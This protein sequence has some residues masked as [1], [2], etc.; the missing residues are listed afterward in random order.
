MKYMYE[1]YWGIFHDNSSTIVGCGYSGAASALNDIHKQNLAKVGPLPAG[2]YTIAEVYDDPER[3]QHTCMLEPARSNIMYGRSGFLIH[4]DTKEEAH[5]AS[6]GCIVAPYW[7][8]H[9]FKAG[10]EIEVI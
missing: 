2:L 8:R 7:V 4:G 6:E 3:G 5:N 1:R 10:D 9:L